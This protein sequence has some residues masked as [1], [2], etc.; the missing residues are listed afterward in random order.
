[1]LPSID[2][3]RTKEIHDKTGYL[4]A[5]STVNNKAWINWEWDLGGCLRACF[6]QPSY[7]PM[8]IE[9]LPATTSNYQIPVN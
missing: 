4:L 9:K 5:G 1:M 6:E 7:G 2:D 8:C 3:H